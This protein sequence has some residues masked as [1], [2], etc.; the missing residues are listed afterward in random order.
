MWDKVV[1]LN[2]K[3][4]FRLTA[5]VGTR[6]VR[7]GGGSVINVSQRGVDPAQPRHPPLRRGQG[8]A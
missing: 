2:L 7:D 5:L 6:M 3:G 4:V 8:R 1:D